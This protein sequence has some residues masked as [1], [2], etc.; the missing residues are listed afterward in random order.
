MDAKYTLYFYKKN[1]DLN[2]DIVMRS[3]PL[4]HSENC[5]SAINW[6]MDYR[7]PEGAKIATIEDSETNIVVQFHD[8]SV[9]R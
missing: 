4:I 6:A 9:F 5:V 8:M 2:N 1:K 3:I 7:A